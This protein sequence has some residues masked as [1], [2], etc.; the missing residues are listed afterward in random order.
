MQENKAS[1]YWASLLIQIRSHKDWNQTQLAH[2]IGVSKDTVSRWENELKYPSIENQKKIGELANS[3]N[4]ASVFGISQV[5]ETSPFPMILTDRNDYVIAASM[6]SGFVA[7]QTVIEQTPED[8][9]EN[10][11]QFSKIVAN[12]G[13]WDKSGNAFEYEFQIENETRKAVIQSVG[14]RGHIFALVQKL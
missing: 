8:E 9:R 5:V 11:A 2:E 12:S 13:F 1:D 14:S 4:V 7:G 3:L 6:C 10:Y